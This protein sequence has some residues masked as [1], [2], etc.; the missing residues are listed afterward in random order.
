MIIL[1]L[2]ELEFLEEQFFQAKL[3]KNKYYNLALMPKDNSS[4]IIN[5]I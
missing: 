4:K 2:K 5:L 1:K 3:N